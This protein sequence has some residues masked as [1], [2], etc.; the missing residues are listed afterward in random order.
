MSSFYG[1]DL[2]NEILIDLN[3]CNASVLKSSN[4]EFKDLITVYGNFFYSA[5]NLMNKRFDEVLSK[6]I[7]YV[8]EKVKLIK[9]FSFLN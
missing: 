4:D 6:K 1:I 8:C 9:F 7:K 5:Y 2:I 3:Q